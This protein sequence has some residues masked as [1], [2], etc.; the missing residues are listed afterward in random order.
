[1]LL[2]LNRSDHDVQKL[3]K[4]YMR[5]ISEHPIKVLAITGIG[6]FILAFDLADFDLP[7]LRAHRVKDL[8]KFRMPILSYKSIKLTDLISNAF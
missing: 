6:G 2:V 7:V 8:N 1:M 4:I 5:L 3:L